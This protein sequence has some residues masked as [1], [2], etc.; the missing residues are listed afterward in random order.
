VLPDADDETVVN[1]IVGAGFGA[2][3][4]R[5][6]ALS[7]LVLVGD[8]SRVLDKVCRKAAQLRLGR[9]ADAG[10]DVGPMISRGARA[11]AVDIVAASER[12]GAKVLL[13]GRHALQDPALAKGNFLGP[14]VLLLSGTQ[15]QVQQ[16]PAYSEEIFGPVLTVVQVDSLEA[17]VKLLNANPY[18]NGCAIFTKSGAAARKFTMDVDVGQV[19]V[20]VPI[21]V[22]LPFFSFTGSKRS[23]QGDLNFYGKAGVHFFTKWKTVT[24]NWEYK[25]DDEARKRWGVSMPK[26]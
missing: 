6:M 14:T 26:M 20:N 23:I 12:Q 4:Q 13:D 9:G 21:P 25:E 17:A 19:G 10:V 16:N 7:V 22:P 15:E 18:G 1:A 11:R 8:A 24:S 2:A 5:C 3:G